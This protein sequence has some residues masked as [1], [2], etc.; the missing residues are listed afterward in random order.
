VPPVGH[1][2]KLSHPRSFDGCHITKTA[3]EVLGFKRRSDGFL[4][5]Q[6]YK[7]VENVQLINKRIGASRQ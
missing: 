2:F 6:T 4:L 3:A 7:A 1:G 5:P